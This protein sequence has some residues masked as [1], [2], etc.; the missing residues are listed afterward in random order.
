MTN[1]KISLQLLRLVHPKGPPLGHI[2]GQQPDHHTFSD[3][4][5]YLLTEGTVCIS[6]V[7]EIAVSP[8][9]ANNES[10]PNN[11]LYCIL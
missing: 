1:N 11:H 5:K 8:D 2:F 10:F 7:L 3:S 9:V 6:Y 4:W